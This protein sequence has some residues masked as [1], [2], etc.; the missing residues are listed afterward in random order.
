VSSPG[1]RVYALLLHL[2]PPRFRRRFEGELLDMY[3]A[4][5]ERAGIGRL[6]L[7]IVRDL[8]V[9]LPRSWSRSLRRRFDEER[10][11]VPASAVVEDL[12]YAVRALRSHRAYSLSM[13]ATLA[14][15]IGAVSAVY[16]VVHTVL[17]K[18]LPYPEP[19]RLVRLFDRHETTPFFSVSI[20]NFVSWRDESRRFEALGAYREDGLNLLVGGE[21][22]RYPGARVTASLLRVLRVTPARGRTFLEEE[23]RPGAEPVVLLTH[24]L[25]SSALGGDPDALGKKLIVSG[26]PHTIVG[27]LPPDFIFPQQP[28][29]QLLVPFAFDAL[30]PNRGAHFLRVLGRL[31]PGAGVE[32][33]T[34][35]LR[36]IAKRLAEAFPESNEGWTVVML[37]L[38]EAMVQEDVREWLHLLFA[39]VAL[40]LLISCVNVTNLA[41]TRASNRGREFALCSALGANRRRL[42]RQGV[43]EHL[44]LA[45]LGGLGGLALA[46]WAV[47]SSTWLLPENL[48][49]REEISLD[50]HLF[51]FAF[52]LSAATGLTVGLLPALQ[53]SKSSLIRPLKTSSGGSRLRRLL[54]TAE[55]GLAVML[56]VT[57]GLLLRT[58]GAMGRVELGFNPPNVLTMAVTP[59]DAT[60]PEP[61][62]RMRL[63]REILERLDALPGARFTAAVHRL[64]LDGGNSS[65]PAHVEGRPA[66]LGNRF[67]AFNYRAVGGDYFGAMG[68]TL[69]S[70]RSFDERETWERGGAVVVNEAMAAALWPEGDALGSRLGRS[71]AGPWL[72]VIGIVRN[73]RESDMD[74]E[75]EAA[76]YLPYAVAPVPSM[77]LLVRSTGDPLDLVGPI[78]EAL[79]TQDPNQPVARFD[80]LSGHVDR[81][82]GPVRFH[83]AV[84]SL[85]AGLALLL[86]AVGIHGVVSHTVQQRR[87]EIGIRIAVGA[88]AKDVLAM[89][90]TQGMAPVALGLALG[91]VAAFLLSRTVESF[92]F[93]VSRLDPVSF[94]GFPLA[95][96][97]VAAAANYFPARAAAA[98]DPVETLR[99]E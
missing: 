32:E 51:L 30:S 8:A 50:P 29:V 75:P 89:T 79:L 63:Y 25:W 81:A 12:S 74:E 42:I 56:L 73:A 4:E 37:P 13:A 88:R 47:S 19:E 48:P 82:L 98:I 22:V 64:P 70:G 55:V 65:F 91:L 62:D 67:P 87:R 49:R 9:S 54:V 71:A 16:G 43:L 86:S 95:L 10:S 78:R 96:V 20:G 21:A 90:W 27:V 31:R 77:V 40:V 36:A 3:R 97:V 15:G 60:Y 94:F 58:L 45:L 14:I 69:V 23:D 33:A 2:Y 7:D 92:L 44:V 26:E 80:T 1:E 76:M 34:G 5:R 57:A 52:L 6:W 61:A 84:L 17:S 38:H 53:G 18:P 99:S 24:G 72:E 59:V 85:F 11:P 39:A 68:M 66:P 83:A 93:G 35:E 28:E 41:L 46:A